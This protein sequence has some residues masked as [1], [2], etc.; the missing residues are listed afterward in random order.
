T[1]VST[2]QPP[3]Y[4]FWLAPVMMTASPGFRPVGS[5]VTAVATVLPLAF[6]ALVREVTMKDGLAEYSLDTPCWK[7]I[8]GSARWLAS[9]LEEPACGPATKIGV[10]QSMPPSVEA[11]TLMTAGVKLPLVN[12]P[13]GAVLLVFQ[14]M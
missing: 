9:E 13:V 8:W 10:D 1:E 14:A 12:T 4:S 5:E 2:L 6:T 11:I 7:I 3:L